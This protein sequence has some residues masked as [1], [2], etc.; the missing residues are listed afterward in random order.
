MVFLCTKASPN[1]KR[2][3]Q[4]SCT[5]KKSTA[6]AAM[7]GKYYWNIKK[8]RKKTNAMHIESQLGE[9]TRNMCLCYNKNVVDAISVAV[10]DCIIADVWNER[11]A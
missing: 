2:D 4:K 3:V 1:V 8:E 9:R 7:K 10:V 6:V 5:K 11:I